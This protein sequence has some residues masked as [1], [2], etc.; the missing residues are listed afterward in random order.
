MKQNI[1]HYLFVVPCVFFC[2]SAHA[3]SD[4]N[5]YHA[6]I[7][8]IY[9]RLCD[10]LAMV[11]MPSKEGEY[12]NTALYSGTISIPA[13]IYY[14]S[15]TYSVV[16]ID[17]SA[18]A[19]CIGLTT[20][21][22]PNSVT[23]IGNNAFQG[24]NSLTSINIPNSVKEIGNN[25][26]SGC[27]SLTTITIPNSVTGINSYTFANCS[28]LTSI[29]IGN[30]LKYISSYAFDG[31]N[32][33]AS[34]HIT[35]LAAWCNINF[36][37]NPL[38]LAHHL[39]MNNQEI[40]NL[41]FPNSVTEISSG[42]FSG[43][44][45]LT[46]VTIPKSVT[47][48]GLSAFE[49]CN[50]LTTVILNLKEENSWILNTSMYGYSSAKS[51]FGDQVKNYVINGGYIG[52][53][54]FKDCSKMTSLSL[55]GVISIGE[56][57]FSG[58]SGL[59]SITI[60]TS[61]ESIY[62]R[63]FM[64]CNGLT[65]VNITDLAAW[66]N[67]SFSSDWSNPLYYAHHLYLNGQEITD[68]VIPEGVTSISSYA[69]WGCDGLT[70]VIIPNSVHYIGRGA[71]RQCNNLTTI[72]IGSGIMYILPFAFYEYPGMK[73]IYCYSTR[74]PDAHYNFYNFES[75]TLHVPASSL[76]AYK[77]TSPWDDFGRIVA[78]GILAT[79]MSLDHSTL[80][81][82]AVNQKTTLTATVTP[83]NATNKKVTWTSSNSSVATVSDTGVVTSKGSGT[84]I[85]TATTTD[86]TNLTATCRVT[87]NI[88]AMGISL[89]QTT[90]SFNALNQTATLTAT[91]TPSNATNKDVTWTSSNTS[92]ATVSEAGVV[93]AKGNGSATITAKTVDGTNLTATCTVIIYEEN[94]IK[95]VTS[96]AGYST[97]F[98]SHHDN[99]L[100][101]GLSALV[102][103]N[104]SN[105]RLTYKTIADGNTAGVV[106]MG[107]A[108]IL[109]SDEKRSKTF[110]L[111]ATTGGA[112]YSGTNLLHGSDKTTMTKGNGYHYKLSYGPTSTQWDNV[113]GW[114]WGAQDGAPFQIEGN[115]AWLVVPSG[116][117]RAE[118]FTIDG[119]ATEITD[120]EP[121]KSSDV[122][123]DIQ[124]RRVSTPTRSG[125]YIKNDKKIIIK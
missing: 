6:V 13:S 91:I 33:L 73:D 82:N 4:W 1:F 24:C 55:N 118:A 54:A 64:N 44:S 61:V 18:F 105:N 32:N 88:P 22:L 101:N 3:S 27:N 30:G 36:Y 103:T 53:Y 28:S 46:S 99:V 89:N 119:D 21:T 121:D 117:T 111:T 57:A 85:I 123:Y 38:K 43:C 81:F 7:D 60:P 68:L 35:D 40:K 19:K 76:E 90:L 65:S 92:V 107:I 97:F 80:S 50:N 10:H 48:I 96:N 104:A 42:A 56:D 67:I 5:L 100:P 9:Y 14:K 51:T 69:F 29:T 98:D 12:G 110:T 84:A 109:V 26:F 125:L 58:C 113:F 49:G 74:V 20:I 62:S 15:I 72:T 94:L 31:C 17:D 23:R 39:Y 66:C 86:G 75:V 106:P 120:I 63:A 83:S 70:T 71:F 34:V 77:T 79:G 16:G 95:I 115:K 114:F 116:S 93:T 124:G 122:Y 37:S 11:E 102:V 8:G 112:F 45:G 108:V 78:I 52:D 2:I 87:V 47:N 41:V 25:A 59:T